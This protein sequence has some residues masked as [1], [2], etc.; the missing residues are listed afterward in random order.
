MTRPTAR[1]LWQVLEPIHAVVYFSAEPLAALVDAGYRGFWMGYFAQRSAPFGL[2][3]PELVDATFFNFTSERVHRALPSAWE[4]APPAAALAARVEGSVRALERIAAPGTLATAA[5]VAD[6]ALAAAVSAPLSGLPLYAANRSLPIPDQPLARL[7]H[8]CTLL[9]EHR[10]DGHV[11]A[12]VGAGIAGRESH[13]LHALEAGMPPELYR[14]SRDF[15][16]EEWA[17]CVAALESRGL[18]ESGRLTPRGAAVKADVE[19]LTDALA[20]KA[21]ASLNDDELRTLYEGLRP[22]AQAIAASGDLPMKTP[23]GL[24]L[25]EI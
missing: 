13:V 11:A 16:P 23:I 3:T 7:W 25:N 19:S 24:D 20:E 6:L 17:S 2:A 4:Y 15:T 14:G 12:L 21:Y 5:E 18:I 8:A 1:Q 22:L 9:R 10:G